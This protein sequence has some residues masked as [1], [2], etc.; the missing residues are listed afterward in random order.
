MR[1]KSWLVG[2]VLCALILSLTG[3]SHAPKEKAGSTA[4]TFVQTMEGQGYTVDD[5]TAN[6][7]DEGLTQAL[8]AQKTSGETLMVRFYTWETVDQAQAYYQAIQK[9]YGSENPTK[10]KETSGDNYHTY[11][12][13]FE[14]MDNVT[15][16]SQVEGSVLYI[17][18]DTDAQDA[19]DA[20]AESL[21]Y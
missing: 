21:G 10:V 8:K 9:G 2:V 12:A 17:I 1:K 18:G 4:D 3:C 14:Q 20:L 16:L 13:A 5:L 11:E 7:K 19:V 6:L 15:I